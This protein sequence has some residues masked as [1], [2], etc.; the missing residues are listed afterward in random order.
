MSKDDETKLPPLPD[1][2]R[3]A[4][5]AFRAERPS[6]QARFRIHAALQA[7]ESSKALP[8]RSPPPPKHAPWRSSAGLRVLAGAVLTGAL[9]LGVTVQLD[10]GNDTQFVSGESLPSRHVS[11]QLPKDGF[12]WVELPWSIDA[13]PKGMAMVHMETP[14]EM[15]FHEHHAE[16]L[17]S[18][19]LV[20]CE[21]N[22]CLHQFEAQTGPSAQPLRV[23]IHK[24]GRYEFRVSHA[25]DDRHI[26]EHFVVEAEH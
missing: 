25:S 26:N 2:A 6:Q 15:N 17:P 12:G 16:H 18:L 1:E 7:A 22:R 14:A 24:P 11:I 20:S 9:M 8:Q 19:Q 13:H 3:I 23:R 4:I 21:G 10:G 5:Q